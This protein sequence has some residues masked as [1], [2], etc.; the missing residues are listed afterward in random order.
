M[1]PISDEIDEIEL[2]DHISS[3]PNRWN[4]FS[5]HIRG[6][7]KSWDHRRFLTLE[8]GNDDV[9]R[10]NR[11]IYSGILAK[12]QRENIEFIPHI[13]LGL[14]TEHIMILMILRK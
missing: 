5:I 2:I 8:Q 11:D 14:F 13:S 9:V 10:R 7:I 12:Y 1:F 6:L 3:I 4:A